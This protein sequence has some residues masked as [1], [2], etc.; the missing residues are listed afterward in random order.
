[1]KTTSKT[2]NGGL[3]G[4]CFRANYNVIASKPVPPVSLKTLEDFRHCPANLAPSEVA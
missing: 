2:G 4:N 1:M 3:G